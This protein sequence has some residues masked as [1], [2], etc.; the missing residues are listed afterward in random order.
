M[1][2]AAA[3]SRLTDHR[4]FSKSLLKQRSR[5]GGRQTAGLNHACTSRG[6]RR[7]RAQ[8]T[9][10]SKHLPQHR[11]HQLPLNQCDQSQ[12]TSS[13]GLLTGLQNSGKYPGETPA[14]QQP[15]VSENL[16]AVRSSRRKRGLPPETSPTPKNPFSSH[17]NRT[18]RCSAVDVETDS[19]EAREKEAES[20]ECV[21]VECLSHVDQ[22]IG[23]QVTELGRSHMGEMR[24]VKGRFVSGE[25]EDKLSLVSITT[26][27]SYEEKD[28]FRRDLSPVLC[29][30]L[31]G[32]R[33]NP[34]A[35][36]SARLSR[37]TG[38][39]TR[40]A[41]VSVLPKAAANSVKPSS[42][43]A[44][45]GRTKPAG[46][47]SLRCSQCPAGDGSGVGVESA[48]DRSVSSKGSTGYFSRIQSSTSATKTRTSPRVLAKR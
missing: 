11:N 12:H 22:T 34:T 1:F 4:T 9:P 6:H 47:G 17:S 27:E 14:Q 33:R 18:L 41:R 23:G 19:A 8:D 25:K 26:L 45:H 30:H 3:V 39:R 32:P 42:A 20:P 16:G 44:E 29:R 46:G 28:E 37:T 24:L 36:S 35:P 43:P 7:R 48:V 2:Q 40:A 31:R 10:S 13:H 5:V 38:S 21:L 15:S